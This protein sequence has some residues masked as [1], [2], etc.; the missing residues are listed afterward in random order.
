M[1][2]YDPQLGGNT[3][4]DVILSNISVAFPN[5]GLVGNMLYP[6]VNVRR[7]SDKYYV[8]GREAWGVEPGGDFRAPGS[9]ANE[10]PGLA[11]STDTYFAKEHSLQI[12]V[13]DEE[14]ENVDNGLAPDRDGTELVT[15]KILLAREIAMQTQA[16]TAANYA[17]GYSV[18]NAG[19]TQWS[20]YV[21]S[22]PIGQIKTARRKIH[23]G[24]FFEPNVG[25]FPYQVMSVLE[26]HPDFIERI[27]YSE[28]GIITSEIMAAL[29]GIGQ[30]IVPGVGY[31]SANPGQ[32]AALGYLWGKDVVLAYVPPRAGLRIPAF[33]YEFNWGYQ[34]SRPMVTE[35]WREEPRKSDLIR[36]SRRYDLKMV[37]LD[38][39]GKEIAGYVIKAAVA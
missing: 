31:N 17:T 35:R 32:T 7:Q 15:S 28:R 5:N 8:F 27:K 10:I 1:G 26:D 18:T 22:D 16:T 21:N 29:F 34:G 33:G 6:M 24:L 14:R 38:G 4:L 12:P 37:A 2:V 9:V 19:G 30:I 23:S 25:I 36:V 3:H 11:V 20:D 39:T 13:T